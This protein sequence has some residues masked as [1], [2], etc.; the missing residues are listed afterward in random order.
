MQ[1]E[2]VHNLSMNRTY[3]AG[4][5]KRP[6]GLEPDGDWIQ[7]ESRPGRFLGNRFL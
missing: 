1:S 5:I 6:S 2:R 4:V 3:K 7:R